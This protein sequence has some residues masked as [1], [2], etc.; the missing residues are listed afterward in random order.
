MTYQQKHHQLRASPVFSP[1]ESS[2]SSSL[3]E[4][5]IV[6]QHQTQQL[7]QSNGY[8]LLDPSFGSGTTN[9]FS[10][11][12]ANVGTSQA[13]EVQ[14]QIRIPESELSLEILNPFPESVFSYTLFLASCLCAWVLYLLLP[15]GVRKQ[16]FRA[17]RKR[18]ARRLDDSMPAAGYWMPVQ[19]AMAQSEAGSSIEA[20][21]HRNNQNPDRPQHYPAGV[22]RNPHQHSR[23]AVPTTIDA[24]ER[25]ISGLHSTPSPAQMSPPRTGRYNDDDE[26]NYATASSRMTMMKT[27]PSPEHP[28]L[29]RIPPNKII[30][31]TMARLQ[32]R[33]IRLVAHGVH[34]DPKR[35]WIRL[36]ESKGQ[37]LEPY[38]T[39]QTEFPRRVPDQSGQVSIVLMRGS[40]H[41]IA[42]KNVLYIDVGKKTHALQLA[43]GG[44]LDSVCLSL[45][46]QNGSLDLQANS[47]LERD[48]LVSCFSM[49]L[50]DIHE[51][52]WR[53]L[54]E[55]SP[56]PSLANSSSAAGFA[57][58][59]NT[60]IG[61]LYN[62]NNST[63]NSNNNSNSNSM[64]P[65]SNSSNFPTPG[66]QG[67][68]NSG[69]TGTD[70]RDRA[71]PGGKDPML[72][73]L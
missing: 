67:T 42:L 36:Q 62:N 69:S 63:N 5:R 72:Q 29:K 14:Q 57:G 13:A 73:M 71:T 55:A 25:S 68:G 39:W 12:Q 52:D 61:Y 46:T 10:L 45:L 59:G 32:G 16:Y 20:G 40:L 21:G 7:H 41:S 56:E 53:A 23:S 64:T 49:I 48:S 22:I 9:Q 4:I 17:S 28:A 47:K 51:E 2:S 6:P 30:A 31:E 54:Y 44:V 58:I 18:Y 66:S 11:S 26:D 34:C 50:D 3:T 60:N 65:G 19:A 24:N 8:I 70:Y 43:K 15:R 38:V 33:G 37:S 27:P 35:V 1:G